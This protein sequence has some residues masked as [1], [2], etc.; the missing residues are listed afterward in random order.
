MSGIPWQ[1]MERGEL[2]PAL[3][4][5]VSE[6][7]PSE[8]IEM[9]AWSNNIYDVLVRHNPRDGVTWLSLKR[10]DRKPIRI[11]RHLQQMKNE[12][13]GPEREAVELFPAES[14]LADSANEYHLWVLPEG[15]TFP[16]GFPE[17][18]VTTDEQAK[19]FTE[20]DHH[21]GAQAPWQ[22]GL[23]TGRNENTRYM[24]PEEAS[25]V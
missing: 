16:L 7:H 18:L 20:A 23:T 22:D 24:T 1:R 8:G 3:R 25:I 9:E 17:G 13:C 14:R 15:H 6:V 21:K 2:N 12:I 11:W 19:H 5:H 4:S 10:H